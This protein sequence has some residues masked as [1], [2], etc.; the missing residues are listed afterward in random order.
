MPRH[1]TRSLGAATCKTPPGQAYL[2][3]RLFFEPRIMTNKVALIL[4]LLILTAIAVDLWL[5]GT[6]HMVFLG[7]RLFELIDW[8]AFWR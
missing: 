6:E 5:F 3:G 1:S 2:A 4:A 8:V 7:K